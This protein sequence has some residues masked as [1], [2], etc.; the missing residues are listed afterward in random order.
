MRIKLSP[1]ANI[2]IEL[3]MIKAGDALSVNG[4]YFD[5][6]PM[7]SGDTLPVSAITSAWFRS[8]VEKMDDGELIITIALPNGSNASPEQKFPEDLVSVPDGPVV[9]PQPLQAIQPPVEGGA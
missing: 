7:G 4:E 1:D 8:D 9:L 3:Y 5:F 2:G 6:S